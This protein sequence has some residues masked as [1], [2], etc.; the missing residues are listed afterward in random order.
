MVGEFGVQA[1]RDHGDKHCDRGSDEH[2]VCSIVHIG[3]PE[4][5]G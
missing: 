1:I 3:R 4:P 2:A 5:S